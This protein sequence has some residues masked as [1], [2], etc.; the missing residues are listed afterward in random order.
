MIR[1]EDGPEDREPGTRDVARWD[2]YSHL[3][4]LSHKKAVKH[5]KQEK[6]LPTVDTPEDQMELSNESKHSLSDEVVQSMGHSIL[7]ESMGES[8][9]KRQPKMDLS[10]TYVSSMIIICTG[11]IMISFLD[12]FRLLIKESALLL[13][14]NIQN[15]CHPLL[16]ISFRG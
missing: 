11:I 4:Y 6:G 2:W 1:I 7:F 13:S 8:W 14:L 9:G 5:S 16:F 12:R 3:A 15:T 10:F